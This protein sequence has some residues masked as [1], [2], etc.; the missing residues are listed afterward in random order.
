M[1]ILKYTTIKN[2]K[3]KLKVLAVIA[4]ATVLNTTAKANTLE[5]LLYEPF[6]A[7]VRSTVVQGIECAKQQIP[8]FCQYLESSGRYMLSNAENNNLFREINSQHLFGLGLIIAAYMCPH[9]V[10][11]VLEYIEDSVIYLFSGPNN[12]ETNI[13]NHTYLR[14]PD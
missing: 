3:L 9:F 11:P 13:T 6:K 12:C 14:H 1:L 10:P 4:L 8:S 2:K 7:T 5:C